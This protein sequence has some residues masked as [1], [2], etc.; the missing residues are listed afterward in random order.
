MLW[1]L[2]VCT[3]V[4]KVFSLCEKWFKCILGYS[5]ESLAWLVVISINH[6]WVKQQYTASPYLVHRPW[7]CCS[8]FFTTIC[9]S[10]PSSCRLPLISLMW[11]GGGECSA[12]ARS[13]QM[14]YFAPQSWIWIPWF[15]LFIT[16]KSPGSLFLMKPADS[17]FVCE[18]T[19]VCVRVCRVAGEWAICSAHTLT[20]CCV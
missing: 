16:P 18:C 10:S 19:G 5:Q 15:I 8:F 17:V 7:D 3:A 2:G 14:W 4:S 9:T 12:R 1:L 11:G 20:P 6:R 13:I